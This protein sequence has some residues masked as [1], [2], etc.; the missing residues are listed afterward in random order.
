MGEEEEEEEGMSILLL[1]LLGFGGGWGRG[2]SE[3]TRMSESLLFSISSLPLEYRGG[4]S[5][6]LLGSGEAV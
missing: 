5:G 3:D 6:S 1:F 2:F 4:T